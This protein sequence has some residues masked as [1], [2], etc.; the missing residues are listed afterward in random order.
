MDM[1]EDVSGSLV[2]GE[3]VIDLRAA[4]DIG[5]NGAEDGGWRARESPLC[6]E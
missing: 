2:D 1:D 5:Y 4:G 6:A 3:P